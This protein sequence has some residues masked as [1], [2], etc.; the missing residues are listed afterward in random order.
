MI[1][2]TNLTDAASQQTI[3]T[4]DDGTYMTLLLEYF[5]GIQRWM[6]SISHPLITLNAQNLCQSP[7]LL[8][9][10]RTQIDFGLAC[11]AADFVDPVTINDFINGRVALY[12]LNATDIANI[13]SSIYQIPGIL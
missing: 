9:P 2:L 10:Y 13:E 12:V 5:G 7:N 11:T 8:R 4:L 3:V 6:Y 1:Q